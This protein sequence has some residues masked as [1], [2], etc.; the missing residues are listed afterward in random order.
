MDGVRL[1]TLVNSANNGAT[2]QGKEAKFCTFKKKN[3]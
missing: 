2:Q 3:V 1:K